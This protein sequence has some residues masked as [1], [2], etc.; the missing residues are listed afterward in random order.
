MPRLRSRPAC[1]GFTSDRPAAIGAVGILSSRSGL[2]RR[3]PWTIS[4]FSCSIT[5]VKRKAAVLI[6]NQY[7]N[8]E[9]KKTRFETFLKLSTIGL[10]GYRLGTH[11]AWE[12]GLPCSSG[13]NGVHW[14][15]WL[16]F[17]D[18]AA[19]EN[20]R[21]RPLPNAERAAPFG[22]AAN[23]CFLLF[24]DARPLKQSFND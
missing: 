16:V 2:R 6:L 10:K 7:T 11:R 22:N 8:E 15:G 4:A 13:R 19:G 20:A 17:L 5:L 21:R 12:R 18:W 14:P 24:L 23:V 1:R 9:P 3:R